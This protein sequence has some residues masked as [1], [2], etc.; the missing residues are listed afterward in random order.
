MGIQGGTGRALHSVFFVAG[1]RTKLSL[2]LQR[3]PTKVSTRELFNTGRHGKEYSIS[4]P[5]ADPYTI[6]CTT[7]YSSMYVYNYMVLV[8][9]VDTGT[10]RVSR[11]RYEAVQYS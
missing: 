4:H 8:S 2:S 10:W 5:S 9:L 6:R 11:T 7:S 3:Q 1:V